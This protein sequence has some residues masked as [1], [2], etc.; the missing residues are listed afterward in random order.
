M[1]A[2][3]LVVEDDR[4]IRTIYRLEL[5]LLYSVVEAPDGIQGW[6]KFE[7]EEPDL[8]LLDLGIPGING[9]DLAK[10]IRGHPERGDTPIIIITGSVTGEHLPERFWLK[11]IPADG[12]LEKPVEMGVLRERIDTMLKERSGYRE[13]PPG[14]GTYDE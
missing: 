13:L 4:E 2:K 14:K 8:V 7:T 1:P 12:F 5:E 10:K 6:K 11:G 9:L 3:L